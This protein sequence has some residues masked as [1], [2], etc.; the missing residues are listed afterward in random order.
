M[1]SKRPRQATTTGGGSLA[2][3]VP[4]TVGKKGEELTKTTTHTTQVDLDL[5]RG[6]DPGWPERAC[7]AVLQV[8]TAWVLSIPSDQTWILRKFLLVGGLTPAVGECYVR[9]AAMMSVAVSGAQK[10][11]LVARCSLLA[12]HSEEKLFSG[13]VVADVPGFLRGVAPKRTLSVSVCAT[14]GAGD[15]VEVPTTLMLYEPHP[16][17]ALLSQEMP[18]KCTLSLSHVV[19]VAA[20]TLWPAKLVPRVFSSVTEEPTIGHQKPT[21][22]VQGTQQQQCTGEAAVEV[23]VVIGVGSFVEEKES[24]ALHM[25]QKCVACK[26]FTGGCS[27]ATQSFVLAPMY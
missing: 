21:M 13:L 23:G 14:A 17:F 3:L 19:I 12:P 16:L 10:T 6:L 4:D 2:A 5:N 20:S 24:R 25:A 1:S 27:C 18:A 9:D 8:G 15:D 11:R 26:K 7:R 22:A